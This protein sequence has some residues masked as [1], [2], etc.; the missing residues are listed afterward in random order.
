MNMASARF[1][2]RQASR[3]AGLATETHDEES[4]ERFHK[5]EQT[6]LHLAET[7]EQQL[8]EVSE[9]AGKTQ[10]GLAT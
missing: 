2:R 9:P 6:Y 8:E 4:R 3:C 7:E 5:L 10:G 1:F